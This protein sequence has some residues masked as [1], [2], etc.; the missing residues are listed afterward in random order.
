MYAKGMCHKC[1]LQ[2][3][4]QQHKGMEGYGINKSVKAK[5]HPDKPHCGKGLCKMCYNNKRRSEKYNIDEKLRKTIINSQLKRKYNITLND[6]IEMYNR[7]NG[8]CAICKEIK[9]KIYDISTKSTK[10]CV[11]HNHATKKV[12][13]LLCGDCNRKLSVIEQPEWVI[14]A[15]KY[16]EEFN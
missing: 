13:G 11:D 2:D 10:I 6:Y 15:T 7:Q 8:M 9:Y 12:R 14:K 16:L 4:H 3:Y 1:Y 5:C